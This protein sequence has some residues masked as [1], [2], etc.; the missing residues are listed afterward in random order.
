[1]SRSLFLDHGDLGSW[2]S[3]NDSWGA[4]D[5][6]GEANSGDNW[7]RDDAGLDAKGDGLNMGPGHW[8]VVGVGDWDAGVDHSWGDGWGSNGW[9]SESW[10]SNSWGSIGSEGWGG[11]VGKGW[12]SQSGGSHNSWGS[13]EDS[14]GGL[15]DSW[16]GLDDSWGGLN[17]SWGSNNWGS[18]GGVHG[19]G[20]H[21][22]DGWQGVSGASE[23]EG[24]AQWGNWG[25]SAQ[26]QLWVS[27][28]L[29]SGLGLSLALDQLSPGGQ[30]GPL[31]SKSSLLGRGVG[32]GDGT[33]GVDDGSQDSV[34][35]SQVEGSPV[36]GLGLSG[37]LAPPG[38]GQGGAVAQ[39]KRGGEASGGDG[40]DEAVL[41]DVLG[42][43]VEGHLGGVDQG[44]G[45]GNLQALGSGGG[46][47]GGGQ[48]GEGDE[49]LHF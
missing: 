47:G 9:G 38:T 13:L 37:P 36:L 7:A 1:M 15:D 12:G 25:N 32:R 44:H 5:W 20:L 24:T 27:L 42:E 43:P 17:D 14:W 22:W 45:A 49:R 41:V 4:Q 23:G 31:L 18:D 11:S 40:V 29:G 35:D 33:V 19:G 21:C 2:G 39:T 30:D 48:G 46:A 34:G 26:E 6:A 16:G 10:G 8:H 3:L 28:S